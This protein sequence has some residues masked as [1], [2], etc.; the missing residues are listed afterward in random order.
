MCR[1]GVIERVTVTRLL[2]EPFVDSTP[3]TQSLGI[4]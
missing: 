1:D 2:P 4:I 3:K